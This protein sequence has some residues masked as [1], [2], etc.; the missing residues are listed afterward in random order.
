[1][2]SPFPGMDPY[3]ERHWRDVHSDL[4][5]LS[6]SALN[7]VL[8]PDLVARMEERIVVD[9]VQ[10]DKP[11]AI[12]PDVRVYEDFRHGSPAGA[13]AGASAVAQPILLE[14]ESEE[15]TETYVTILDADGGELVSVIEFISPANKLPGDGREQCRKKRGELIGANANFTEIDLVRQGPWRELLLPMIAPANIQTAYRVI[16]RRVHPT[17]RVELYPISI[18]QRLPIIPIPLREDDPD[19]TLDLQVLFEQVYQN[20][21]YDRT[22]YSRAC[23]PPLEGDDAAWVDE[24]LRNAGLRQAS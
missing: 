19:V 5:S 7:S 14:F 9:S 4:V 13:T 18:R 11:R 16:N 1:M 15:H 24:L 21:R 8:P 12:Y 17:R 3:L 23:E 6:R 20:G 22:D 10:Y 2:P